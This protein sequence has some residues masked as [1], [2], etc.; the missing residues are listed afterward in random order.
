MAPSSWYDGRDPDADWRDA[1]A[2]RIDEHRKGTM[3][4]TVLD[5]A[6]EPV[7]GADV[8]VEQTEHAFGFGT[9][10]DAALLL[11]EDDEY[12]DQTQDE[13]RSAFTTY[14]NRGTINYGFYPWQW[15]D[16][17]ND[18]GDIGIK[19]VD[20]LDE[21]DYPVHGHT[22][23]W[24]E[25]ERLP[26]EMQAMDDPDE[27]RARL[28]AH[29]ADQVGR[30]AGRVDEWD[31][32][33][34]AVWLN[35]LW[36][37]RL[38]ADRED[39]IEWLSTAREADPAATLFVNEEALRDDETARANDRAYRAMLDYLTANGAEIDG[40][41]FMG[42]FTPKTL[43]APEQVFEWLD[44]YA[45]YDLEI[46]ITEFD[47]AQ[48]WHAEQVEGDAPNVDEAEWRA[49]Q[50]DYV[51]DFLLTVVSHPAVTAFITWG[52]WAGRM[53]RPDGAFL[54]EEFELTP[55]GAAYADIVYDEWW[56]EI[57]GKTD[58]RGTLDVSG[59][60]GTYEVTVTTNGQEHQR[61]VELGT[62][63]TALVIRP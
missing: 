24:N 52:F 20:W 14:F 49:V 28:R 50:A 54:S 45:D 22:V 5:A 23:L 15:M 51:R 4:L 42:H 33:N 53:W 44:A 36:E 60:A 30:L 1:A 37:D 9:M 3:R 41:G 27:I 59:F 17:D 55:A 31:V 61:E 40:V 62:D 8:R 12:D 56:T 2:E 38:N 46:Q 6:G 35:D 58:D 63:E 43:L 47:V 21:R 25:I 7:D 26:P 57:S 16:P 29:I 13:F 32:I 19:A 10:V 34:H 18:A 11:G 48:G 39:W